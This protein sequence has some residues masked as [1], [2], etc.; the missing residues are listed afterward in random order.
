MRIIFS[1]VDF[2]LL[3]HITERPA[4]NRELVRIG[5]TL[6]TEGYVYQRLRQMEMKGYITRTG[7]DRLVTITPSGL[8]ALALM[9][10][11]AEGRAIT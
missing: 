1:N 10:A 7:R 6:S 8:N 9:T 2:A 5:L 3:N 4:L 11:E